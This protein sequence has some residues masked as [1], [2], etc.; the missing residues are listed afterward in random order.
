MRDLESPA[1]NRRQ[2]SR[3]Y[4]SRLLEHESAL[5]ITVQAVYQSSVGDQAQTSESRI[6]PVQ[7]FTISR[8]S[9]KYPDTI[10]AI[11]DTLPKQNC[12][13]YSRGQEKQARQP[14]ILEQIAAATTFIKAQL[15]HTSFS[16]SRIFCWMNISL[17][18]GTNLRASQIVHPLIHG[19][20]RDHRVSVLWW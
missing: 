17:S 3:F 19:V 2:L 6:R 11:F 5:S 10:V 8:L 4:E 13:R 7:R 9:G 20:L 16:C 14:P 18:P 1:F 12:S 15:S